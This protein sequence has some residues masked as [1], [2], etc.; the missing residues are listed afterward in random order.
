MAKRSINHYNTNNYN[1]FDET[2]IVKGVVV[3]I[4]PKHKPPTTK[5]I[6]TNL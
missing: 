4:R 5:S 6:F 1:T 3:Y 2:R